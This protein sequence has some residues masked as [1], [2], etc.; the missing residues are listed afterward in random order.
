MVGADTAGVGFTVM[1]NDCAV[2]VQ[3]FAVGVAV[4]VAVNGDDVKL[5]ALKDAISPV[6]LAPNPMDEVLLVQL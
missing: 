1:V 6:P 4:I 2:P 5:V 3:L